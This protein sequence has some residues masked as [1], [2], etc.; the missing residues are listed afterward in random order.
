MSLVWYVIVTVWVN[1]IDTPDMVLM[2]P[3]EFT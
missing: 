1:F 3:G 2:T